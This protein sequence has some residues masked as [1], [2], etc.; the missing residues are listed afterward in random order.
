MARTANTLRRLL[1]AVGLHRLPKDVTPTLDQYLKH[2]IEN[3]V[4][5]EEV[6]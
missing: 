5:D 2:K 4:E 6:E 1:E 3:E